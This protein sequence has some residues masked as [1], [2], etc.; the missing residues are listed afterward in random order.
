[1]S[2]GL[3]T[4]GASGSLELDTDTFTYQ[5]MY[6]A[7]INFEGSAPNAVVTVQV[8]DFDPATC[9]AVLLPVGAPTYTPWENQRNAMP[10]VSVASG[11]VTLRRRHP[12]ETSIENDTRIAVRLLVMRYA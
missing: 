11:S 7:V 1:M 5:V 8:P 4:W 9:C 2:F 3:R 12:N 10:F 6:S